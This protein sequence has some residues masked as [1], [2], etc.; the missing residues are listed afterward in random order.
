VSLNSPG[1]QC[2]STVPVNSVATHD[3]KF[4]T[5]GEKEECGMSRHHRVWGALICASLAGCSAAD[6]SSGEAEGVAVSPRGDAIPTLED[7]TESVHQKIQ[8]GDSLV[9]AYVVEGDMLVGYE[10]LVAYYEAAYLPVQEKSVGVT[11]NGA[12]PGEG[13]VSVFLSRPGF[14]AIVRYCFD[15][16]WTAAQAAT[17]QTAISGAAASWQAVAGIQLQYVSNLDGASCTEQQTGKDIRVTRFNTN[18]AQ[19]SFPRE[20]NQILGLPFPP[21]GGGT[22][23]HEIGHIYGLGHEQ[24]HSRSGLGCPNTL[25]AV[26]NVLRYSNLTPNWDTASVM[27]NFAN[28]V[29]GCLNQN[30]TQAH[31]QTLSAG[32]IAGMQALYGP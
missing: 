30:N 7:F 10:T 28:D 24:F 6:R 19:G 12:V 11:I 32:D 5:R 26:P 8:V 9:D 3:E 20:A 18:V 21:P 16:T 14:P 23:L 22:L 29:P 17:V 27:Q 15:T 2:R 4:A 13:Q 1:Q 25:P 31:N